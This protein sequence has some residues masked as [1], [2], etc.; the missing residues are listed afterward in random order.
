MSF[1]IIYL[2]HIHPANQKNKN[3]AQAA[4]QKISELVSLDYDSVFAHR[5]TVSPR[6]VP[7]RLSDPLDV[8]SLLAGTEPIE[9]FRGLL[10]SDLMKLRFQ[11]PKAQ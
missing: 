2:K 3:F 11:N 9:G 10:A 1:A 5:K 4:E 8:F 6:L 7:F